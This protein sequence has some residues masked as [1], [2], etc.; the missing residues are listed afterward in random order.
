LSGF[1]VAQRGLEGFQIGPLF[2][3]NLAAAEVLLRGLIAAIRSG[4][5]FLDAPDGAQN[6]AAT[7]LVER[8]GKTEALRMARMCTQGRPWLDV[9][10]VFG[11]TSL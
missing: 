6:A 4:T 9:S 8:F 5:F 7:Q 11:I 1:G 10:R 2:A 3:V